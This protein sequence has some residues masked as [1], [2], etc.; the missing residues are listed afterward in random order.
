MKTQTKDSVKNVKPITF[1]IFSFFFQFYI[2]LHVYTLFVPPP[3][4]IPHLHPL[5]AVTL[6]NIL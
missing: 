4:H 2:Y 1:F 5:K 3:P 6:N